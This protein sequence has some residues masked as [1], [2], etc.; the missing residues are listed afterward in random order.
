MKIRIERSRRARVATTWVVVALAAAWPDSPYV[1]YSEQ[2]G[3]DPARQASAGFSVQ[4][5]L[6]NRDGPIN[7]G[8]G[9]YA[10]ATWMQSRPCSRGLGPNWPPR[11]QGQDGGRARA[12]RQGPRVSAPA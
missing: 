7:P 11:A 10:E 4:A 12:G 3:F 1:Q 8:R 5:L 2:Y 6:D 9:W